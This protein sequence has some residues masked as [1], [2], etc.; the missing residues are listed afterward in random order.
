MNP[1]RA[2]YRFFAGSLGGDV[3]ELQAQ[4]AHHARDV[5]RLADGAVV[6]LFDGAGTVAAGVLRC[7]GRRAAR[8]EITERRPARRSAP[9]IEVAFAVPKGKRLDWL[10]EK[11]TEL[12]AAALAPV[13]FRR[14]VAR[15]DLSSRARDRWRGVCIAAAKQC[16]ADL[17]PQI[18]PP[19]ELGEVLRRSGEDLGI[20]G[21]PRGE[22]TLAGVLD[23]AAEPPRVIVLVGP[24]GGMTEPERDSAVAAGFAPV[25]LGA[26]TLRIETAAVAMLAAVT[27]LLGR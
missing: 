27:A 6:E 16:G 3:V 20:F 4:E 8:V 11:A 1:Q 15:P 19:C 22:T 24:E 17:L 9:A 26:R 14:S 12:G 18:H 7:G 23:G 10:L 25:R 21:D 13:V 2:P 5:L